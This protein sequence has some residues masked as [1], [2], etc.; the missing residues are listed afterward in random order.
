MVADYSQ[1][2]KI[3][4][5]IESNK[6]SVE[7]H[8][9]N[10][11]LADILIHIKDKVR[12]CQEIRLVGMKILHVDA[13]LVQSIFHGKNIFVLAQK[14]KVHG[15]IVWDVSGNDATKDSGGISSGEGIDGKDGFPGESG[16]NIVIICNEIE[17]S[18]DWTVKSIGGNG[19]N[20]QDGGNG[21]NGANGERFTNPESMDW[22]IPSG[23]K[24][25]FWNKSSKIYHLKEAPF[26]IKLKTAILTIT[27]K[28]YRCS[29]EL[30]G[31]LGKVVENRAWEE[32][33]CFNFK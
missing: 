28:N 14:I 2:P 24:R 27:A 30:M 11:R 33:V 29:K 23:L 7:F 16:G 12:D 18:Q 21:A 9:K 8:G 19:G 6:K 4:D 20:G 15:P 5:V 25:V 22:N 31:S 13:D 1:P 26:T 10:A 17:N 3:V 32:K